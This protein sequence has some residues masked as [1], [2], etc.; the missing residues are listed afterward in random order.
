MLALFVVFYSTVMTCLALAFVWTCST[1][2]WL[3]SHADWWLIHIWLSLSSP[4]CIYISP[5]NTSS[6]PPPPPHT[7]N[8]LPP[9]T[10]THLPFCLNCFR[11]FVVVFELCSH[12]ITD[13]CSSATVTTLYYSHH[14]RIQYYTFFLF[15]FDICNDQTLPLTG[16]DHF[17][18]NSG[19]S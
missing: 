1:L 10:C 12:Q 4:I 7:Y 2:S 5:I 18:Q 19:W 9:S 11:Y 3:L 8:T 6:S 15:N 16:Y 14:E 13:L 17:E